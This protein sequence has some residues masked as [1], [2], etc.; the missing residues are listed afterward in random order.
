MKFE[1][2][3]QMLGLLGRVISPSECRYL[4]KLAKRWNAV[5]H[6]CLEWD[7]NPRSR[8]L[9][10]PRYFVLWTARP[11]RLANILFVD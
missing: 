7:S 5:R 8:Y 3:R 2:Y 1:S 11:L 10:G 4:H 6:R 9:S